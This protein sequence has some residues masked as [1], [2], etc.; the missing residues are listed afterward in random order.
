[1]TNLNNI[2]GILFLLQLLLKSVVALTIVCWLAI[3]PYQNIHYDIN[4]IVYKNRVKQN[5]M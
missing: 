3:G 2:I 1:M 4:K 5:Y